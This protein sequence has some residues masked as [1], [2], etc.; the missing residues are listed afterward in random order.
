MV[1]M[2]VNDAQ[3]VGRVVARVDK[4]NGYVFVKGMGSIGGNNHNTGN[5][6]TTILLYYYYY[7][8]GANTNCKCR[9]YCMFRCAMMQVESEWGHEQ[10][11]DIQERYMN[12]YQDDVP[13]LIKKKK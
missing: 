2:M 1:M 5:H 9:G 13:E 7:Y 11:A 8:Y 10:I 4:C 12:L 6:T 3:N